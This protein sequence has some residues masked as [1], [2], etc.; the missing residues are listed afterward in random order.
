LKQ[1]VQQW[2]A[3]SWSSL[4]HLHL[5]IEM[6][7]GF[8]QAV[9][10]HC[11]HL[12]FLGCSTLSIKESQPQI[13]L[14]SLGGLSFNLLMTAAAWKLVPVAAYA[15]LQAPVLE[16]ITSSRERKDYGIT[17]VG[18]PAWLLCKSNA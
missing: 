17:N 6:D 18:P 1:A 4:R 15:A 7:R 13:Q 5:D 12:E 9:A 16:M 8:L 11:P 14:P 2:L 3:P 10:S